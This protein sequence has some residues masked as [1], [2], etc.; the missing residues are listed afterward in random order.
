MVLCQEGIVKTFC[1]CIVGEW[2]VS[3][4]GTITGILGCDMPYTA[5]TQR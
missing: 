5:K 2:S 3:V 1:I 4:G